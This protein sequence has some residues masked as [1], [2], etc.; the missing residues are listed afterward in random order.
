MIETALRLRPDRGEPHLAAAYRSFQTHEFTEARREIEVALRLLPNDAQATFLDARLDRHENRWDDALVKARRAVV[1]DP[2]NEFFVLWTSETYLLM[3]RYDDGEEFVRQA[4]PRYP[5]SAALF[6]GVLTRFKVAEGDLAGARALSTSPVDDR[7]LEAQFNAAFY[8]R[9]YDSALKIIA[10]APPDLVESQFCVKS[11]NSWAEAKV[12]RAQGDQQ[13]AE[14]AFSILR[15]GQDANPN[16]QS[17]NEWYYQ[18]TGKI[19]AGLNR[20]DEAIREA[21]QAMDLLP[22]AQDP[23]SGTVMVEC[24]AR[25]Y[26]W[27]GECNLAI[28]QLEILAGVPSDISYGDLRFNPDWDS[29]RGDPHFE[30]IVETLEPNSH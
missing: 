22:I 21:R 30:K 27:T 16:L 12:Y 29:L 14:K 7:G 4:R 20:K 13:K 11:P 23:I 3:R 19:D 5:G 15:Q 2:H 24:L 26:A 6:D 18:A 28:E 9:D 8:S 25:I 10:D 17:R 1:L